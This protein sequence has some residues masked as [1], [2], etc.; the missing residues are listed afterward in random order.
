MGDTTKVFGYLHQLKKKSEVLKFLADGKGD[1]NSHILFGFFAV[2]ELLRMECLFGDYHGALRVLGLV[3]FSATALYHKVP[4]CHTSLYYYMGFAYLM[5]RRYQD[6][7]K[8]FSSILQH[9]SRARGYSLGYQQD[10]IA[11]K[12]DQMSALMQLAIS[13]C[14]QKVDESLLAIVKE[15]QYAKQQTLSKGDE[16]TF[17]EL[18][19]YSC[20]KFISPPPPD[21]ENLEAFNPNEAHQRQ[22]KLF[23]QE[24]QQQAKF[25]E[26]RAYMRLYSA[27]P[28]AK[29]SA[30]V[31]LDGEA[32]RQQLLCYKH[33]SWQN[34]HAEGAP[35]TGALTDCSDIDFSLEG[36]MMHMRASSRPKDYTEIWDA[37]SVRR[38]L[39]SVG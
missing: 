33:K 29:L 6:A 20:P 9:L 11:K 22:L 13:L 28:L 38:P 16:T 18:F 25:P 19:S 8:T 24:V 1:T 35:L 10:D 39:F 14:P 7:V 36:G 32:L 12:T 4:A 17:E 31:D 2:I 3:P 26:M 23:L 21:Y 34:V 27:M 15:K 5:L 30:F 37:A